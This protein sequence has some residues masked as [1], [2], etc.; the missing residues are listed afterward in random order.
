MFHT[1]KLHLPTHDISQQRN[2]YVNLSQKLGEIGKFLWNK[3]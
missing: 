2:N 1:Q 3:K